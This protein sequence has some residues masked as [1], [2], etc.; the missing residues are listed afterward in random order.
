MRQTL[1][2][3]KSAKLTTLRTVLELDFNDQRRIAL[4]RV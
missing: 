3:S 4:W 2:R 1:N